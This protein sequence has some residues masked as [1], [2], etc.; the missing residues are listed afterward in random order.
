MSGVNIMTE[1]DINRIKCNE[2][3]GCVERINGLEV[4]DTKQW[5]KF[6]KIDCRINQ[7]YTRLNIIL[8]SV[9]TACIILVLN[10]AVKLV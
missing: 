10:L 6:D 1:T 7:I 3:T 4:S 9:V 8:G 5:D 2:H